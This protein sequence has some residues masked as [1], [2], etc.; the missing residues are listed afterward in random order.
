MKTMWM[1]AP[2]AIFLLGFTKGPENNPETGQTHI[3]SCFNQ[4]NQ[5]PSENGLYSPAF[6]AAWTLL[7]DNIVHKDLRV[8]PPNETM[9]CLN[10]MPFQIPDNGS[11][12]AEAGMIEDGILDQIQNKLKQ[13]FGE[14]D[15]SLDIYQNEEDGIVCYARFRT[16]LQ[17]QVPFRSL[18]WN[19]GPEGQSTP[20]YCFGVPKYG[21]QPDP[22]QRMRRQVNLFDYRS[23]E[24]FIVQ[25]PDADSVREL[26]LARVPFQG[27][28]LSTLALVSGR[29]QYG[30]PDKMTHLDELVIPKISLSVE[31]VYEEFIGK[32]L[33][34]PGFERFTFIDASQKIDF[35]LNES[36][37]SATVDGK[38]IHIKGPHSRILKFDQPFLLILRPVGSEEPDLVVWIAN[39]DF[40]IP[41]KS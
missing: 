15:P 30:Y 37:A 21:E 10:R 32:H 20:V 19:F 33:T 17:F 5:K 22:D 24:D 3:V 35:T 31:Q 16:S 12:V 27:D 13:Q 9:H 39:T 18:I 36:G 23:D 14:E 28:L 1:L 6:R 7:K 29:M 34:N 40:L 41:A 38:I 4:I 26:I 8:F 25:I 2:M 11:W